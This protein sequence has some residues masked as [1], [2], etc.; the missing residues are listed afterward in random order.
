M[1]PGS[2]LPAHFSLGFVIYPSY[3]IVSLLILVIFRDAEPL[4]KMRKFKREILIW[5]FGLIRTS[6]PPF[7][8]AVFVNSKLVDVKSKPISLGS[9]GAVYALP[10]KGR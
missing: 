5:S 10:K 2:E 9:M 4:L 6:H 7:L 8:F 3:E 1:A